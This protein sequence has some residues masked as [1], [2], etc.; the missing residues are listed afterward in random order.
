MIV[1]RK[2]QNMQHF[3]YPANMWRGQ[4]RVAPSGLAA[5]RLSAAGS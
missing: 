3:F 5:D 4:I 2:R 1:K